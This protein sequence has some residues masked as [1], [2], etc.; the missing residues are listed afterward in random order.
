MKLQPTLFH[1]GEIEAGLP[2][3]ESGSLLH[4]LE[5]LDGI[6]VLMRSINGL[7]LLTLA[8]TLIGRAIL[9]CAQCYSFRMHS[10]ALIQ[11]YLA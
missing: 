3:L 4:G 9:A 2:G 7:L 10:C 5:E 6:K 11:L 1:A 8:G